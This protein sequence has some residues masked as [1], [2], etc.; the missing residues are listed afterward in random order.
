MSEMGDKMA[1][2][3]TGPAVNRSQLSARV[4]YFINS[5]VKGCDELSLSPT[6][7]LRKPTSGA[8]PRG[9][10]LCFFF[11]LFWL[12]KLSHKRQVPLTSVYVC[13]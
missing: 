8:V 6:L 4:L 7:W 11:F 10:A 2:W 5:M 3:V 12:F 9:K 13:V 1:R